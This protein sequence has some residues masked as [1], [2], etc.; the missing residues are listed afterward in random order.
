MDRVDTSN[1]SKKQKVAVT[2][3]LSVKRKMFEKELSDNGY[4]LSELSKECVALITNDPSSNSEKNKKATAWNIEKMT[5]AAFRQ[6]Y[7]N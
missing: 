3:K 6:K 1:N 5:E 4:I 2:G 7:F